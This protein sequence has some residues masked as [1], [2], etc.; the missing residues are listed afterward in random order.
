M[1]TRETPDAWPAP[2]ADGPVDATVTVPG[3]KSLTNRALVL[4]ALAAD[5]GVS[6]ISG[7][8][9]S[10]DTDLMIAAL[11]TLGVAVDGDGTELTVGGSGTPGPR[12]GARIDCGLA[13]T[14]LRFLPPVAAL[15]T[16]DVVFDGDE[17][18]RARPIKPLLDA[19]RGLGVDVDGDGLPFTV[20]GRGR[21]S[22]GTVHIDASASSQ[23]VSGLLLSGARFDNGLTVVHTGESVP[24]APHVA[25]TVAMLRDAGVNVDDSRPNHWRVGP[26]P[27]AARHWAIEPDLSNATPFVAAAIVTGGVVRIAGWPRRSKQPADAIIATLQKLGAAVQQRD[28]HLEVRGSG[29]YGGIDVDLHDIGELTPTVAAMAAL[30][31]PGSVSKLTGIAHLRGHET[32]RLAALSTEINRLGGQCE[33]TPDGLIITARPLRGGRWRSYADHRMATAGAIIGLRVPGVTVEDI[34]TTAKT[35]PEFPQLWERLLAGD[36]ANEEG[37]RR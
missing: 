25:M 35:L 12:P 28:S 3:S 34:G 15:S 24:S 4:A 10:R 26:G 19:L 7:A 36:S 27:V 1:S 21:V 11:Q 31:T 20:R 16:A 23:F 9:R 18:A 14:V 22:G 13:G 6:T 2:T 32:D 8:L 5:S 37:H 29:G 17:Q 33:E 30:A